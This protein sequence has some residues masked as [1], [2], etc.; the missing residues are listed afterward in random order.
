MEKDKQQLLGDLFKQ[1]R[2]EMNI[3]LKE[4]ENATSIRMNYLLAIEEGNVGKQIAAVY[5]E[6]FTRQYAKFLGLDGEKLLHEHRVRFDKPEPL[7]ARTLTCGLGTIE[8]R[9]GPGGGVKWLPNLMWVAVSIGVIL[10]AWLFARFLG[11]L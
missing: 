8:V 4:V 6:G 1:R 2:R 11:V 3:S 10:L 5:A 7:E 9:G